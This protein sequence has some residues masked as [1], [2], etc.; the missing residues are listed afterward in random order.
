MDWPQDRD[1]E[2]AVVGSVLIDE[3]TLDRVGLEVDDFHYHRHKELWRAFLRMR[4]KG[5]PIDQQTVQA[6]AP[7]VDFGYMTGC[8]VSTPTAYNAEAYARRVLDVSN[9]R[10]GLEITQ[11]LT[12]QLFGDGDPIDAL[13]VAAHKL[14]RTGRTDAESQTLDHTLVALDKEMELMRASPNGHTGMSCGLRELEET[15]GGVHKRE[16][17]MVAGESGVGKSMFAL[18]MALGMA[19]RQHTGVYYSLEMS[20]TQC[21]RRLIS[22]LSGISTKALR[23]GKLTEAQQRNYIEKCAAAAGLPLYISDR[24]NWSTAQMRADLLKKPVDFFVVDMLRLVA[25]TTSQADEYERHALVSQRLR[26]MAKELNVACIAVHSLNKAGIG[27]RPHLGHVSGSGQVVYDCDVVA[28]LT[29]EDEMT[30]E[31]LTLRLEK[32]REGGGGPTLLRYCH[33]ENGVAGFTEG[34]HPI[35]I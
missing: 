20:D 10:R 33:S 23:G 16:L 22:M 19:M 24:P 4:S 31:R 9:R 28:M 2:R 25:D 17:M 15:T 3:H 29:K 6:Y 5:E 8:V 32:H 1:A 34:A 14:L 30:P 11:E 18:Q 21:A 7:D 27:T 13:G 12:Q 35:R 26:A